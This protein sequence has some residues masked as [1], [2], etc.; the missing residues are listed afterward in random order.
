[1]D[2]AKQT[3][4][5]PSAAVLTLS[6]SCMRG[7]ELLLRQVAATTVIRSALAPAVGAGMAVGG[8]SSAVIEAI[9]E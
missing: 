2:S 5:S 9:D 7:P 4:N 6:A 8:A 1:M 3:A